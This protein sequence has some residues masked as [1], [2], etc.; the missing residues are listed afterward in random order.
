[1]EVVPPDQPFW[2]TQ[3]RIS[4]DDLEAGLAERAE[5][6][7]P[8]SEGDPAVFLRGRWSAPGKVVASAVTA[9]AGRDDLDAPLHSM[10]DDLGAALQ[11]EADLATMHEDL[12]VGRITYPIAHVAHAAGMAMDPMPRPERVL[13]ALVLSRSLPAILETAA[14]RIT[15]ARSIASGLRLESF[16][17]FLD[18]VRSRLDDRLQEVSPRVDGARA[19]PTRTPTVPLVR[20]AKPLVPHAIAMARAFLSAD[21][22]LRES[23]ETH[24]EGMLG[25]DEVASRFP[26]GLILAWL[27]EDG[28]DLAGPVDE[29][30]AFAVANRFRYYDHPWS[31]V[32][33]DTIGVSLRLLR[34]AADLEPYRSAV[35]AVLGCLDRQV[36]REGAI[37]VW[38][39]ECDPPND[40]P[41]DAVALGEGCA[42]VAAHLLIGLL[43]HGTALH[44]A[45]LDVGSVELL[46]RIRSLGLAANVNYPPGYA[47]GVFL[48]LVAG[49]LRSDL[50]PGVDEAIRA[51]RPVLDA[52]LATVL[53]LVP[54]TAQEA[55]LLTL[56]CREAGSLDRLDERWLATIVKGQRSDG[57]WPGEPFAAAPNRGGW[58][59]WYSSSALTTALCHAAL[60][61]HDRSAAA[62]DAAG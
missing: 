13:G 10:L 56:A 58:V 25:A 32:D 5:R 44:R 46:E 24:R 17:G 47:I 60:L 52:E 57:G 34:H 28:F 55:A 7:G 45:T 40:A 9:V 6:A 27:C 4:L 14:E 54:A 37:A 36:A 2:R 33:A 18:E 59:S 61:I 41:P 29:F 8:A 15:S 38:I 30:L 43:D 22:S 50:A 26:A 49:L 16:A 39:T 19:R 20:I 62:R 48:R 51:V 23:W 3:E 11:I 21:P 31:G 35:D 53:H 12:L 42:T 1:M